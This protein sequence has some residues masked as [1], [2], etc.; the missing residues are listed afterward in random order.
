MPQ[1]RRGRGRLPEVAGL[2]QGT[3]RESAGRGVTASRR[4]ARPRPATVPPHLLANQTV[5]ISKL[6]R[7]VLWMVGTLL[8]FSVMAVSIRE[9][10][11]AGLSI[12]EIL[13][14]RSGVAGAARPAGGAPGFARARAAAP[15]ETEPAAQHRAL[16]LAICLGAEPHH[17]AARHG[18][19][20]R[21]HHAG[22]DC[23]ARSLAAAR[24]A[25]AEPYRRGRARPDWRAGD[26]AARHRQL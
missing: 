15:H 17:A 21:I 25:P 10:A 11:T 7:V 18:V 3:A 13:A 22:L 12:F 23:A 6:A 9:L 24:A 19:R 14:I 20:S 16:R 5:A 26:P 1:N 2:R 8:S 4:A